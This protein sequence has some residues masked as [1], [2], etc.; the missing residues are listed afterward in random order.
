MGLWGYWVSVGP[1]FLQEAL[2]DLEYNCVEFM[3]QFRGNGCLHR[4]V[5]SHVKMV[6]VTLLSTK[7]LHVF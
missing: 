7:G 6:C 3:D 2:F 4:L 1:G 5:F